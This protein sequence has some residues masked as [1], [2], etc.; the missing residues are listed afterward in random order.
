M[1]R[2]ASK[3]TSNKEE[4]QASSSISNSRPPSSSHDE[5]TAQTK[6][7]QKQQQHSETS[8]LSSSKTTK[9]KSKQKS[10]DF[11][12]TNLDGLVA[13]DV[14]IEW[15]YRPHMVSAAGLIF[16]G[17]LYFGCIY[18]E[19]SL[20]D[21]ENTRRSFKAA[22][23]FLLIAGLVIFP[24][25]P[26]VRP[27]PLFWRFAFGVGVVYELILI[28]LLFQSKSGARHAMT[29]FNP[30]LGVP[31]PAKSYAD[32]CEVTFANVYGNVAD[33]FFFS[34]F[35]GWVLKM[36]MIRDVRVC[37]MISIQWEFIEMIFK[38]MLPNFAECW[39]DQWIL[40][41]LITNGLGIFV[42]SKLCQHFK[43]KKFNWVGQ[44]TEKG[45]K[46]LAKRGLQQLTSPVEWD[47]MNWE[48]TTSVK[49]FLAI[50]FLILCFHVE[51]L[52]HFFLKHLLWVS[53]QDRLNAARLLT[54]EI[55]GCPI[56]KQAY[57]YLTD[58]NCKRIG[59]HSFL[60]L[61]LILTEIVVIL[62][63]SPGEFTQPMSEPVREGTIV[64]L[65]IYFGLC[66]ACCIWIFVSK[67]PKSA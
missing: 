55:L 37:W 15:L 6:Q 47:D 66:V 34:H 40:D 28:L 18:Y 11:V 33:I 42:G 62:K 50:Q 59:K 3:V 49:R 65:S 10:S 16:A 36:L 27:H 8:Y 56:M 25:G 67:K 5:K 12:E 31:L 35:V 44:P 57:T 60:G 32:N 26:F 30:S 23:A 20:D 38:H 45:V 14:T 48:Y 19:E 63:F 1:A 17:L 51:E 13:P 9:S 41:V 46:Q 54:W 24:N 4:L 61:C 21:W 22:F 39:W 7:Q 64:G 52:N 29:L 58:P 43:L 53:P 2:K